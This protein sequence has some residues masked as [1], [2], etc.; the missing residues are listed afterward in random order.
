MDDEEFIKE[1]AGEMLRELGYE[2]EYA[3]DG[4]EA[5]EKCRAAQ[6]A[7]KPVDVVIMDLTIPGGLG[8]K[9]AVGK[10][11]ELNPEIKARGFQ[12]LFE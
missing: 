5:I 8:G 9:E 6:V 1:I 11:H 10:L 7:G 2:V 12:R 3:K 4:E